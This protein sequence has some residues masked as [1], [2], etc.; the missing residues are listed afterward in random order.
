MS[1]TVYRP[2]I[3]IR[4][5]QGHHGNVTVPVRAELY[6]LQTTP[7]N[8]KIMNDVTLTGGTWVSA[9]DESCVEY[10][11]TAT[12]VSG[13]RNLQQGMFNGG[14]YNQPVTIDLRTENH[15]YQLKTDLNGTREIF[16]VTAIAT[17]NNDDALGSL[18][19]S[20][21]N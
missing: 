1:Q 6:G 5:K 12:A 11:I 15:T 8:Y 13:G 18:I 2:I 10:N 3:A 17:T 19:W 4:L 7:F 16:C 14:T 9:G 20:E 21:F